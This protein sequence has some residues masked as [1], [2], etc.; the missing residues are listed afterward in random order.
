MEIS[1]RGFLKL[2]GAVPAIVALPAMANA[3]ETIPVT[4]HVPKDLEVVYNQWVT[5]CGNG[6]NS[7]HIGHG[8]GNSPKFVIIK[9]KSDQSLWTSI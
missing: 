6:E 5:Y 1:R 4:T 3:I 2:F 9:R 8:F 7:N